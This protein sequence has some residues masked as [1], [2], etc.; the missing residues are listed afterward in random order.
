M[1]DPQ[2]T[3]EFL[4]GRLE[5]KIDSLLSTHTD[6]ES[7]LGDLEK[8]RARAVGYFAGAGAVVTAVATLVSHLLK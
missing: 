8:W 1:T 3:I 4:L 6:H 2:N 7:R 5:A